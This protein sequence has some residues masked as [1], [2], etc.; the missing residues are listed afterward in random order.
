MNQALNNPHNQSQTKDEIVSSEAEPLILVDSNDQ[1]TGFLDKSACHDGAGILHRAFSLFIFNPAGEL[2]LQQ[3]AAEKRLWPGYWS[4]SCCSHPRRGET[5]DLAVRRRLQQELGM[6][7]DL[8]FTYKFEYQARF[9]D[10]GAEH[11]L[12]WVY[13]GRSD[14]EPVINVTEISDWRWVDPARLSSAIAADPDS[15]TPWLI[16]E[17]ERLN[18]EFP[19]RLPAR[20]I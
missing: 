19:E 20:K 4:N 16:M 7:A 15:Y 13:V 1:E 18:R 8:Q 17:W 3:R 11:E 10:L 2:L 12:C 9:A 5:M 14:Q 6:A